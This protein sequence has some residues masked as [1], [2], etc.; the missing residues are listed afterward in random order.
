MLLWPLISLMLQAFQVNQTSDPCEQLKKGKLKV[1]HGHSLQEFCNCALTS[2]HFKK[3]LNP[4]IPDCF[5]ESLVELKIEQVE[6]FTFPQQILGQKK[7][8]KLSLKHTSLA[9]LP[10]EISTL[11]SLRELDL[12]GT[13]IVSLPDG[14][15]HLEKIDL[16]LTSISKEDQDQMRTKYPKL[17]IFFSSP[18]NCD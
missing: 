15:D 3:V 17:K 14:L 2:L 11:S 7:L 8:E 5:Q 10:D 18:C 16:R 4:I 6:L 12:R 13:S 1:N 9:Y